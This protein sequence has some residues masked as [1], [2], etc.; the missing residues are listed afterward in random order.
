L[1][2]PGILV[3]CDP[4]IKSIIMKID[5]EEHIFVVEELD[6]QHLV[7]QEK[8]LPLLKAKLEDVSEKGR[9]LVRE[10]TGANV[11]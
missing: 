11:V 5:S 10:E 8:Q 4:S 7:I 9:G 1:T 6:D 2:K 3:E